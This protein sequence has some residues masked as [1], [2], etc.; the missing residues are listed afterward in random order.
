MSLALIDD[1]IDNLVRSAKRESWSVEKYKWFTKDS[2]PEEIR[3]PGKFKSEYATST[4]RYVGL[5]SKC[6][7]LS[8]EINVKLS[9]KG[10]PWSVQLDYDTFIQALYQGEKQIMRSFSLINYSAKMQCLVTKQMR[11]KCVSSCYFK[12]RVS[13]NLNELFPLTFENKLI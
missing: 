7:I 1:N 10:T 4:G 12:F 9:A 8:D 3:C 5:C 6:Y 13:A 11:K 2:S